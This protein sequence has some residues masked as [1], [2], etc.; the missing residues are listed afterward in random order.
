M[1]YGSFQKQAAGWIEP[2]G[3]SLMTRDQLERLVQG[4]T[5]E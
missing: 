2:P 3:H 1:S 4:E 5:W